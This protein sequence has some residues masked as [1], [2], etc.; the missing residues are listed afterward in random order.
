MTGELLTP[1]IVGVGDVKNRSQRVEDAVE[2]M[3]LMIQAT[4]LALQD[5]NLPSSAVKDIL[6]EIDSLDVIATW[7]WPYHD[8]PGLLARKLNV[9]PQYKKYSAHGGNQPVKVLDE[10]ARRISKGESKIAIVTGGEALASLSA[11]VAAQKMPPR[12]WPEPEPNVQPFSVSDTSLF[13]KGMSIEAEAE[14]SRAPHAKTQIIVGIGSIHSV[15][16]PIHVYAMYENGF[17]AHR[18]QSIDQNDIES[19]K[20]C[21]GTSA[22]VPLLQKIPSVQ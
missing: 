9:Q 3:Q 13:T 21:P 15:G 20:L 6:S 14:T 11:C 16:L 4:L 8:L 1:I 10:A 19:G 7:T 22:N 2:P 17:R 12:S 5:T 18:G